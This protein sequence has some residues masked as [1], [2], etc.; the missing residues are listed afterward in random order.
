M[1]AG[2]HVPACR[3]RVIVAAVK[4]AQYSED[5]V[6]CFRELATRQ[7]RGGRILYGRPIEGDA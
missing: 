3:F 7:G 2:R 1:P 4:M 5:R 6:M